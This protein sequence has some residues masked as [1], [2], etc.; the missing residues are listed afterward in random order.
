MKKGI[1]IIAF[2]LS[3]AM[4]LL[5]LSA[6]GNSR[7]CNCDCNISNAGFQPFIGSFTSAWIEGIYED[8]TF[9]L[10]VSADGTIILQRTDTRDVPWASGWIR[11]GTWAGIQSTVNADIICF[12][13]YS[14][15]DPD[16][17]GGIYFAVM[18]LPDGRLLASSHDH[19]AFDPTGGGSPGSVIL[20]DRD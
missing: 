10:T 19:R 11:H 13:N 17:K 2:T 6:C 4:L 18:L 8:I 12:I 9:Y 14:P 5:I 20:F 3:A 15:H 16:F 7:S 1:N